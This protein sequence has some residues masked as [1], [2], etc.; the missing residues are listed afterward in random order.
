MRTLVRPEASKPLARIALRGDVPRDLIWL[1]LG[2]NIDPFGAASLDAD[3]V[4]SFARQSN[5]SQNHGGK[6]HGGWSVSLRAGTGVTGADNGFVCDNAWVAASLLLSRVLGLSEP[7]LTA[8]EATFAILREAVGLAGTRAN[9]L[10]DGETGAGKRSLAEVIHRASV[11]HRP[12]IRVDCAVAAELEGE[13]NAVGPRCVGVM[14]QPRSTILLDRFAELPLSYQERLAEEIHAKRDRIRYIATSKL[15]MT[16][17]AEKGTIAPHLL[18][19][20]E[21]TLTLPPLNRRRADLVTLARYFLPNANPLLELDPGALAILRRYR[22]AGN[23]RE[24]QNLVTRLE[25]YEHDGRAH[26]RCRSGRKSFR[27]RLRVRHVAT[28]GVARW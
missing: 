27:I 5:H 24:L 4:A 26:D 8:S 16:R 12:Q 20:F 25:I 13:L 15:P 14:D 3:R 21:V 6:D 23:V 10:I 9:V 19:Q 18:R 11:G 2:V 7:F 1:L 28:I 22:F 17:L